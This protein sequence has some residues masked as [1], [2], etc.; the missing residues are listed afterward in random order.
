MRRLEPAATGEK[1]D[2]IVGPEQ[3]LAGIGRETQSVIPNRL[4]FGRPVQQ[5]Q[6][7]CFSRIKNSWLV[8]I[9]Y[10]QVC[11][12]IWQALMHIRPVG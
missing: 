2:A 5:Q 10:R 9:R 7:G 4:P 8:L 1:V 3:L 6:F 11:E 12:V